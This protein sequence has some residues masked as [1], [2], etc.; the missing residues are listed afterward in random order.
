MSRVTEWSRLH[1]QKR[2]ELKNKMKGMIVSLQK[3]KTILDAV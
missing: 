3:N 2:N 1:A